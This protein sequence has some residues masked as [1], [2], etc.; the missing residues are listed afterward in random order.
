[1]TVAQSERLSG[2]V[3]FLFTDIEGCTGLLKQ[4]GRER[5]GELLAEQQRLLREAFAAHNG[6][7]IDTQGDS[8]FSPFVVLLMRSRQRSLSNERS[9]ITNG[10]KGSRLG[11]GWAFTAARQP[12]PGSDTWG[13]PFIGLPGSEPLRTGGRFCSRIRPARWSRTR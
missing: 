8:F 2:T 6:E 1:M 5:Y 11:S 13:S 3:T 9:R 10:Q 4:L 12:P 7:E